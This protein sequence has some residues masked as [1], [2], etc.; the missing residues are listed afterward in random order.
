[1]GGGQRLDGSPSVKLKRGTVLRVT[2]DPTV[3]HEQR[4]T[5]PCVLVSDPE[6][7]GAQ[8]YPMLGVIPISGTPGV[9]AFYPPLSPGASGLLGP[10]YA[11][12]DQ[13]RTVDKRRVRRVYGR[14]KASELEA[15]DEGLRL[16]LGL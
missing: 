2:L 12:V 6:I 14:L 15:V 8:R 3:G 1:M 4:G 9:G 7:A 13:L 11:L 5:R 10:S 16:F